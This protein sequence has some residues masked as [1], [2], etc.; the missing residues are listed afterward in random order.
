MMVMIEEFHEWSYVSIKYERTNIY[1]QYEH[2]VNPVKGA[3]KIID[4]ER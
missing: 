1:P 4:H 3:I 2:E